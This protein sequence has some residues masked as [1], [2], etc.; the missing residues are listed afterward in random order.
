MAINIDSGTWRCPWAR[1]K[2]HRRVKRQC[3]SIQS[4]GSLHHWQPGQPSSRVLGISVLGCIVFMCI[5]LGCPLKPV[6]GEAL[7]RERE[8]GKFLIYDSSFS[9]Q[10]HMST[11][12]L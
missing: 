5:D 9:E 4:A 7:M 1:M 8:D 11:Q 12:C 6:G 3:L 2:G 10:D